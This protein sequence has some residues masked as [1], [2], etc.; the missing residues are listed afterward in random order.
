[1]RK[2]TY[3]A[4]A[5]AGGLGLVLAIVL[6]QRVRQHDHSSECSVIAAPFDQ[7]PPGGTITTLV[8]ARSLT[9]FAV[10][11]PDVRAARPSNLTLVWADKGNVGLNFAHGKVEITFT[12]PAGY[13]NPRKT[14]ERFIASNRVTAAL[15][16]V[17]GDTALIITPDTD[18]CGSNPAWV[19][20]KRAGTDINIYSASY[21]TATLLKVADSLK[22]PPRS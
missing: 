8:G 1:M 17:H 18:G 5:V 2:R 21:G 22:P 10:L 20:F 14:F 19:E 3:A 6:D 7:P 11:T 13:G 4:I 12:R 16:Q 15:G 9:R